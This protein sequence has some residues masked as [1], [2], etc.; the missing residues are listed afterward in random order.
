MF[1]KVGG[2]KEE[3]I[4][5]NPYISQINCSLRIERYIIG[6]NYG[7]FAVCAAYKWNCK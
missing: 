6:K 1:G 4:R 3:E 7:I 2:K 5:V